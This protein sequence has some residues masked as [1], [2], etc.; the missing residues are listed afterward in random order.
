[1][2]VAPDTGDPLRE[3]RT[4]T[5]VA[6]EVEEVEAGVGDEQA[7][8]KKTNTVTDAKRNQLF[9]ASPNMGPSNRSRICNNKTKALRIGRLA[10]VP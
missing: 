5:V 7:A 10:K 6:A 4:M 1:V 3:S 2:I 9:M 8:T